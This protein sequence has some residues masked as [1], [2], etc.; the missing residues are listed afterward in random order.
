M[1]LLFARVIPA[2]PQLP[3]WV[4]HT[5]TRARTHT[6][7]HTHTHLCA[8]ARREPP[9]SL[10]GAHRSSVLLCRSCGVSSF[11]LLC[12]YAT[13]RLLPRVISDACS[14]VPESERERLRMRKTEGGREAAQERE[15]KGEQGR[16]RGRER[17][18][19]VERTFSLLLHPSASISQEVKGR[20]F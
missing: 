13:D 2:G 4:S 8:R 18:R 14:G 3:C 5:Y 16:A 17:E 10:A 9:T 7:T 12:A 1:A 20:V 15:G 6:Y 11:F 19:A